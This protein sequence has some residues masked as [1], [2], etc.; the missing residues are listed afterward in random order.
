MVQQI[1]I[2]RCAGRGERPYLQFTFGVPL[3]THPGIVFKLTAIPTDTEVNNLNLQV[4]LQLPSP[5]V[6][7]FKLGSGISATHNLIAFA[8]SQHGTNT[9]LLMTSIK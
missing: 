2:S 6:S 4:P 5:V 8:F 9:V 1:T 3:R 7:A